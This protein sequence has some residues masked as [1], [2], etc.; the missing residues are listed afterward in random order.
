MSNHPKP[1]RPG[2]PSAPSSQKLKRSG[3]TF[4]VMAVVVITAIAAWWWRSQQAVVRLP[5]AKTQTTD[6][7]TTTVAPAAK[8]EFSEAH[9][10]VAP[11]RWRLR[12]RNQERGRCR[13][14]GRGVFESQ[15]NPRGQS[16][17]VHGRRD[18]EGVHRIARRELSRLDLH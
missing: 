14:I 16:R 7:P 9:G 5:A 2:H 18:D 6:T 11:A 13:Q 10:Q 12:H 1:I 3:T 17:G 15:A 4:L 8:P